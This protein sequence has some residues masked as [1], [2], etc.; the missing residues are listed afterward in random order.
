MLDLISNLTGEGVGARDYNKGAKARR[1]EGI[2][3][4][5]RDPGGRELQKNI[6]I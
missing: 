6:E 4:N 5:I 2:A 1:G 3:A